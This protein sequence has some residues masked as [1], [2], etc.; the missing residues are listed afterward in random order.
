MYCFKHKDTYTLSLNKLDITT[1]KIQ[2][3]QP[4]K[5]LKT[6][7]KVE[8]PNFSTY[9]FETYLKEGIKNKQNTDEQEGNN[10]PIFDFGC[11]DNQSQDPNLA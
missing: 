10:D 7:K 5:F 11:V 4:A 3:L 2:L 8:K 1:V 9:I 6:G